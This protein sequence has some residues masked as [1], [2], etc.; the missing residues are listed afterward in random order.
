MHELCILKALINPTTHLATALAHFNMLC[1]FLSLYS[2]IVFDNVIK[3]LVYMCK[4]S[5]LFK[6]RLN[7]EKFQISVA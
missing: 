7:A 6:Y 2:V 3:L 5:L 4:K 1:L